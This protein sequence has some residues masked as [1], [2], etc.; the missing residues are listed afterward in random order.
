[1]ETIASS[2]NHLQLSRESFYL[3]IPIS[4]SLLGDIKIDKIID[5]VRTVA[6]V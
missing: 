6:L 1:M 3:I 5:I 2:T 4:F